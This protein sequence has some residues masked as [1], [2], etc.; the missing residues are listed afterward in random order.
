MRKLLKRSQE[1]INQKIV[2][3]QKERSEI[4]AF[5]V[6]GDPNWKIID[7]QISVLKGEI[8]DED[9]IFDMENELGETNIGSVLDALQWLDGE[10]ISFLDDDDE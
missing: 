8:T 6:F 1:E 3:L 2:K 9:E 7:A 5:S 4:A 10:D